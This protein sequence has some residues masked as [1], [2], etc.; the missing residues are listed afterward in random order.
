MKPKLIHF[1]SFDANKSGQLV[2]CEKETLPFTPKRVYWIT[3]VSKKTIRGEH[4]HKKLSQIF[5]CLNGKIE[6]D[7]IS[8]NSERYKFIL[9]SSSIGLFVPKMFWRKITY[10]KDSILLV[11]ADIVY[12]KEDYV[13][14]FSKF[15]VA[16]N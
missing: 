14:D 9:T 1:D 3:D 7:L 5:V 8:K 11:L 4:A 12:E 2:V 16:N 10:Q 15:I 6:V 13:N